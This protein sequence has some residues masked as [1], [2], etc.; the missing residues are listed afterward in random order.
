MDQ[1]NQKVAIEPTHGD[2]F[3]IKYMICNSQYDFQCTNGHIEPKETRVKLSF[4]GIT[5]QFYTV[6]Y[7]L[8]CF[9]ELLQWMLLIPQIRG[10]CHAI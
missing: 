10:R 3:K 9:V 2:K 8:S 4:D 5:M 6:T 1:D 7:L